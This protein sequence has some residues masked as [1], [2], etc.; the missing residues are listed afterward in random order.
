MSIH[1]R[2]QAKPRGGESVLEHPVVWDDVPDGL[3][4]LQLV[5]V[6]GH[7]LVAIEEAPGRRFFFTN[8]GVAVKGAQ[9]LLAAKVLGYV[10]GEEVHEWRL[11]LLTDNGVAQLTRR[12]YPFHSFEY[13]GSLRSV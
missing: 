13:T 10:D 3:E 2:F 4:S 6:D 8:E 11:D 5:T 1:F 9:G 12:V 7:T